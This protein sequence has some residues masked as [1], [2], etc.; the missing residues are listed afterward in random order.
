MGFSYFKNTTNWK[1]GIKMTI[2]KYLT[3]WWPLFLSLI[4]T[5]F[6]KPPSA[7]HIYQ[8][9]LWKMQKKKSSLVYFYF[10]QWRKHE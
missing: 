2:K 10:T 5:F 8:A 6:I 7:H 4:A 9:A 3:G 1:K